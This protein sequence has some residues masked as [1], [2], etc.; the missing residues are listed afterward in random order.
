MATAI[1]ALPPNTL[2]TTRHTANRQ[3]AYWTRKIHPRPAPLH[4][5][6]PAMLVWPPGRNM[7]FPAGGQGLW[8]S[9]WPERRLPMDDMCRS[10][11]PENWHVLIS[12]HCPGCH[13]G[14]MGTLGAGPV[15]QPAPSGAAAGHAGRQ[16]D[17]R[18]CHWSGHGLVCPAPFPGP[19]M[20]L[21]HHHR[22]AGRADH[23]LQFFRRSHATA[24]AHAIRLGLCAHC[25]ACA[26]LTADDRAGPADGTVVAHG[27]RV[28]SDAGLAMLT[29]LW[30]PP[31]LLMQRQGLKQRHVAHS[32]RTCSRS[33]ASAAR[34]RVAERR[35]RRLASAARP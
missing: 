27:G 35:K 20:A 18:L 34:W 12:G 16:S 30:K 4:S 10:V 7:L 8:R 26:W 6:Q 22:P 17:W 11:D 5:P 21:V 23:L 14:R 33:V 19:G 24:T 32:L 15:A 13:P 9:P 2:I 25:T 1:T 31:S 3:D 28:M 29:L